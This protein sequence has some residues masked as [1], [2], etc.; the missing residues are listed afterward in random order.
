MYRKLANRNDDIRRLIERGYAVAVDSTS[1]LIVRDIPYL[2]SNLTLQWGAFVTALV[3]LTPETVTQQNHQV[4]F[5]GSHPYNIDGSKIANIGG[6][7]E[8]VVSLSPASADVVVQRQFSNKLI[9]GGQMMDYPNFFEK[10]ENYRKIISGPA[11]ALYPDKANPFTF[12]AVETDDDSVFKIRDTLSSRASI[13]DLAQKFKEE[14]VAVIGLGGTGAYV[15]DLLTKTPIKE[16]R[17]FDGDR[18]HIHNAFRSPGRYETDE[19]DTPKAN[20]YQKR[21]ENFRHGVSLKPKYIDGTCG[22]DLEGVTFAFVCVDKAAARSEI[23]DLLISKRI[24]FIDVGMGLNRKQGPISGQLRTTY[25]SADTAEARKQKEYAPLTDHPNEEYRIN[26]QIAELNAIN[27]ALAI[28]EYKKLKGFYYDEN[29]DFQFIFRVADCRIAGRS[30][31][32][33]ARQD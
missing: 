17:G 26:I 33:E 15:L 21:Y 32:D 27:A 1:Y 28:V 7:G 2:D 19:F 9:V 13:T 20:V 30:K 24:P 14:V 8:A 5:A 31:D 16:I 11:M 6:G 12:R 29:Q 22:E 4:Y 25:F 3:Y 10:I 23:F 18:Y